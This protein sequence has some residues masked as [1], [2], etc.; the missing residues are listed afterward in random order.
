MLASLFVATIKLERRANSAVANTT[1]PLRRWTDSLWLSV[2][3]SHWRHLV[4][5]ATSDNLSVNDCSGC[6]TCASPPGV[7]HEEP[8]QLRSCSA[9]VGPASVS[10]AARCWMNVPSHR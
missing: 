2:Y 9:D 5:P 7:L 1:G 8:M 10:A 6:S 3:G 4:V